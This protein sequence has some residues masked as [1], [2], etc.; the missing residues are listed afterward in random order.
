MLIKMDQKQVNHVTIDEIAARAGVSKTTVSRYLNNG[1]VSEEKR[2]RIRAIIEETGYTPSRRAQD[3]RRGTS[4]TI[5]VLLPQI[6]SERIGRIVAGISQVLEEQDFQLLLATTGSHIDRELAYLSY[7]KNDQVDGILFIPDRLTP[8]H[9]EA[10][11]S[12]TVPVVIIGQKTSYASCVYHDEYASARELTELL[13][14]TGNQKIGILSMTMRSTAVGSERLRG[15]YAALE[16]YGLTV[17]APWLI[18][19]GAGIGDGYAAC[20]KL[21]QKHPDVEAV[22]CSTDQ[23]AI[24]AIKYLREQNKRIPADVAVAGMGHDH[25]SEFIT[26]RL[27]TVHYAYKTSGMEAAR[28]LLQIL[29]NEIDL[30]KQFQLGYRI[31]EQETTERAES[32]TDTAS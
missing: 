27:T 17:K 11:L 28:I 18:R 12:S 23:L 26:P 15:F 24:G 16:Q 13:L 22:L 32:D 9:E 6:D 25:L 3:L 21:L 1:S 10:I 7:F 20:R 8:K 30:H 31:I 4:R 19:T 2:E 14:R 5:G 29:D